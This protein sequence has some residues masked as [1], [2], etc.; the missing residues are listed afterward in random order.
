MI[1]NVLLLLCVAGVAWGETYVSTDVP[2]PIPDSPNGPARSHLTIL[3]NREILDVNIRFTITHTWD[4]DLGIYLEA[5]N[6]DD[7]QL[8]YRCGGSQNNGDNYTNT[9]LDDEAS[10]CICSANPPYTGTF[11]PGHPLYAFDGLGTLGEWEFRVTDFAAGDT[12]SI[13][14]W[15]MTMVL[16]DTITSAEDHFVLSPSSF[17]LSAYPNPFN[18]ETTLTLAIPATGRVTV[19]LFDM[20]GREVE[21]LTDEMLSPGLHRLPVHGA[22][23]ASGSYFVSAQS[24]TAHALMKVML[25]K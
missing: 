13:Q 6:G 18:S 10:G 12:G 15:Q 11:Q 23:L 7:V 9:I 24:G 2:M 5:P 25:I 21:T 16:G 20:L 14:A 19:T 8:A 1:R 17:R 22:G 3:V 4:G